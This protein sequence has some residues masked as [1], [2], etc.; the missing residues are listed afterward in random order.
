MK[1]SVY[2]QIDTQHLL[3][4]TSQGDNCQRHEAEV[5]EPT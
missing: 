1:M 3:S 4:E 5:L 2:L